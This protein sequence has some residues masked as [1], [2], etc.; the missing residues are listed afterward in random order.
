MIN[1][2]DLVH[3]KNC[4]GSGLVNYLIL[5]QENMALISTQRQGYD[6]CAVMSGKWGV[7]AVIKQTN[8]RA[9]FVHCFAG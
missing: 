1:L 3:V 6:G 9:Y 7:Q 2:I 4:C 8:E 5:T